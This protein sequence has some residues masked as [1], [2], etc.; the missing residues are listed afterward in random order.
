MEQNIIRFLERDTLRCVAARELY[1][2]EGSNVLAFTGEAL[3][4]EADGL[5]ALSADS[6]EGAMRACETVSDMRLLVCDCAAAAPLLIK[7]YG[8]TRSRACYNVIYPKKEPVPV[9]QGAFL[10]P[11]DIADA[12]RVIEC[13]DLLPPEQVR[14]HIMDGTLLGGYVGGEWA[15]FIGLHD[16]GSMGMLYIFP[17]ARRRGLGYTLEGLLINRLL[18]EGR[19]PWAQI[20]TDNTASLALQEK[21]GLARSDEEIVWLSKK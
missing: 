10:A 15:G 2:Q 11:M 17:S 9:E 3:L 20:F 4:M 5:Y 14:R 12:P 21:L 16:E 18:S 8:F 19:L 1:K 6:A 7:R 13:Y